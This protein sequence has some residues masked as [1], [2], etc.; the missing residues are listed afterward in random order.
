MGRHEVFQNCKHTGPG[1]KKEQDV[2]GNGEADNFFDSPFKPFQGPLP[3]REQFFFFFFFCLLFNNF[4][5]R[6]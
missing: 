3:G 1:Q 5:L 4:L 6:Q 2:D